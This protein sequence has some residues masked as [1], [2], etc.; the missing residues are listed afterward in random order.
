MCGVRSESSGLR[1]LPWM[2]LASADG[3]VYHKTLQSSMNYHGPWISPP[4]SLLQLLPC[5]SYSHAPRAFGAIPKGTP[6]PLVIVKYSYLRRPFPI[7]RV[8]EQ[9]LP[10]TSASCDMVN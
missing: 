8:R 6:P 4:T 10:L 3:Q 7:I 2:H 1:A 9:P 5:S